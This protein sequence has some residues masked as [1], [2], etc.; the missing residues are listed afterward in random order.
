LVKEGHAGL[1][2][3]KGRLGYI[4]SANMARAPRAMAIAMIAPVANG[5]GK[6]TFKI[7]S[8][9][10]ATK[11]ITAFDLW[12][13]KDERQRVLWPSTIRLSAD[14]FDS[15]QAHAVPLLEKSVAALAHSAVALDIYAWLA[16]RLHRIKPEKPAFIPWAALKEQFG[17]DYGH[18]FNFKRVFR[19]ALKQ[20]LTQY[21]AARLDLDDRGMT[22]WQS[23]PP[24]RGRT[25]QMIPGGKSKRPTLTA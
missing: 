23:P 18:M 19:I 13:P 5:R 22:A 20:V 15:L 2:R 4:L 24:V 17:P 8:D 10:D 1:G 3:Q 12:F 14:Y 9:L 16:Q 7:L 25:W 6:G 21:R 11:V